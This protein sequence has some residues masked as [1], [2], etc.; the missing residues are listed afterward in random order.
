MTV[1]IKPI[2]TELRENGASVNEN[3]L[4]T[5]DWAKSSYSGPEGGNCVE[6]A[7]SAVIASGT[8]PVR[9]S[10]HPN[11]PI[12]AFPP[13]AFVEFITAVRTGTL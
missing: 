9:D 4:D 2:G 11:G 13:A 12:L 8:V 6:W 7:P 3:E 5:T 10:K 1:A